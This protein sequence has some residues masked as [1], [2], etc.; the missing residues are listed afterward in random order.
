MDSEKIFELGGERRLYGFL[1][2]YRGGGREYIG[3]RGRIPYTLAKKINCDPLNKM[4]IC[5]NGGSAGWKLLEC[6]KHDEKDYVSDE[7]A[8]QL[9]DDGKGDEMYIEYYHIWTIEGLKHVINCIRE[10]GKINK[11]AIGNE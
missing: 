4:K 1:F 5:I 8:R 7:E 11:W 3:V 2:E 6:L 9:I 10:Y